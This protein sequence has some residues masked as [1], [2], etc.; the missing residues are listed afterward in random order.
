MC[1]Y[2]VD[3]GFICSRT[4]R[5]GSVLTFESTLPMFGKQLATVQG[6]KGTATLPRR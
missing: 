4:L 3:L 2:R 6:G 1:H 5:S